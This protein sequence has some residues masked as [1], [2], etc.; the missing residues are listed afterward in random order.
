[1]YFK[2][3]FDNVDTLTVNA[4]QTAGKIN[5]ML[6][7]TNQQFIDTMNNLHS[8]SKNLDV[9]IENAKNFPS[10]ILFGKAPPKLEPSKL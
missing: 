5:N 6:M 10:Y 7:Q 4:N 8:T 2:K 9:L 3:M 1:M